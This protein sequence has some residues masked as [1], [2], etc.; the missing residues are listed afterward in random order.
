MQLALRGVG[1]IPVYAP[2]LEHQPGTSFLYDITPNFIL[3]AMCPINVVQNDPGSACD[4]W[5][6]KQEHD[7][8]MKAQQSGQL[9]NPPMPPIV[10]APPEALTTGI[11]T[12]DPQVV[13]DAQI[14]AQSEA[15][16]AANQQ[17]FSSQPEPE[18][19]ICNTWFQSL[20]RASGKCEFGSPWLFGLVILVAIGILKK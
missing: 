1:E 2:P 20:N 6:R 10:R 4:I 8:L 15:W 19:E 7:D 14:R 3:K 16:R 5:Q 12:G 9:Q 17:F 11:V 18:P 13:I